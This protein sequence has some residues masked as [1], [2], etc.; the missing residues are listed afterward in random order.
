VRVACRGWLGEI[1]IAHGAVTGRHVCVRPCV[2]VCVLLCGAAGVCAQS[3][4]AFEA[5]SVKPSP[6][7]QP[8]LKAGVTFDE[9][10]FSAHFMTMQSLIISAYD[11][12]AYSIVG[13]QRWFTSAGFDI[14][15]TMPP[16]TTKEQIK[17]MM[18]SMLADRFGMK[19][20]RETREAPVYALVVAKDGPRMKRST[21]SQFSVRPG[22]G[23]MEFYRVD[24]Q[25]L[26]RNLT[27]PSDRP[28]IDRTGLD[29][30]FDVTLD[31]SSDA[32]KGP[33]IFTAVQEQL[34]LR[35]DARKMPVEYFVIDHI[36]RPSG[37]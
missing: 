12:P 10:H 16:G 13:M 31:R 19:A 8:G 6:P 33:S 28:I 29:G 20:H 5:V 15:A 34:G 11:L 24:M 1:S 25:L 17:P 18:Q 21:A 22:R 7:W 14:E 35:L 2:V 26:I 32:D 23:H 9:T 37:N 30:Y 3:S 27:E 4:P 36:E